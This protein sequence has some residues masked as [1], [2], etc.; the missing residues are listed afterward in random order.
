[1]RKA[2][3]THEKKKKMKNFKDP[4]IDMSSYAPVIWKALYDTFGTGADSE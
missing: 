4:F 1:M 2:N 3:G